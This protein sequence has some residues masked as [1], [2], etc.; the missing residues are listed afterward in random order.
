MRPE[1]GSALV[2]ANAAAHEFATGA[3]TFEEQARFV[4]G[5]AMDLGFDTDEVERFVRLRVAAEAGR[6]ESELPGSLEGCAAR[7]REGEGAVSRPDARDG[8]SQTFPAL[9]SSLHLTNTG[10]RVRA[11][12]EVP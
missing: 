12:G 4:T 2:A 5:N 6:Q 8:V 11:V 10:G 3:G 9:A 1:N 7:G